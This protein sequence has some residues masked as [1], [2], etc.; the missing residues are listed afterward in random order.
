MARSVAAEAE[1]SLALGFLLFA[2]LSSALYFLCEIVDE[3]LRLSSFPGMPTVLLRL[4]RA[5]TRL[6]RL[7]PSSCSSGV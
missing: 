7:I 3:V 2:F 5:L 6:F 1:S 4:S